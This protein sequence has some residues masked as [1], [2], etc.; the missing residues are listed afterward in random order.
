MT[1]S[2][3]KSYKKLL[4][5]CSIFFYLQPVYGCSMKNQK[6]S[7]FPYK[8]FVQI[9]NS[10]NIKKCKE[11]T[12]CKVGPLRSIGSGSVIDHYNG[13]TL[14]LTAAH[15]CESTLNPKIE[16]TILEKE[17]DIEVR[18]WD[19]SLL[20]AN[21]LK[22]SR[23]PNM[24]LCTIYM[25][26]HRQP[27]TKLSMA[28]KQPITGQE[29]ISMSAPLGI[30]HPP[31]VPI[32]QG[33]YSGD[34][35]DSHTSIMTVPSEPGSSGG[36]ILNENREIIGVVYA[37]NSAFNHVTLSVK[38]FTV[39]KFVKESIKIFRTKNMS[40]PIKIVPE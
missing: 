34:I 5:I 13:L 32:L 11:D 37:V 25:I 38:Y 15:V 29:V 23:D 40:T 6:I 26:S 1:I 17:T 7:P 21:I 9:F 12:P 19:N 22:I 30:Y 8:G 31:A 2:I 16:E 24:D 36:P 28:K 3:L 14:I 35:P 10:I 18:T 27:L 20:S 39:A 33:R 4:F